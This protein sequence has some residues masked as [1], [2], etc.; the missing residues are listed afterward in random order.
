[1]E[2]RYAVI[3]MNESYIVCHGSRLTWQEAHTLVL[4][5]MFEDCGNTDSKLNDVSIFEL[6][7][8][9]PGLGVSFKIGDSEDKT[10]YYILDDPGDLTE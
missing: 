2:T 1:M 4:S 3:E 8:N 7:A 6:E 10:T 5:K 9:N